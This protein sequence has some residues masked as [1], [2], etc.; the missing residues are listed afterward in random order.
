MNN[1]VQDKIDGFTYF[2]MDNYYMKTLVEMGIIGLIFFILLLVV[3]LIAGFRSA[4]R[5]GRELPSDRALDS[6]VRNAGNDRIIC[7]GVLSGLCGVLVHC[8]YENIFEEPYMMA[9]FWGLAAALLYLGLYAPAQ[10]KKAEETDEQ[11]S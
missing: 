10:G 5:C 8:Y 3:L 4:G 7:A 9:Y 1:Q 6:L 2:Y 11:R